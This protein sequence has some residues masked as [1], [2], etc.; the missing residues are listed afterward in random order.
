[1]RDFC[2]QCKANWPLKN[3]WLGVSVE[4]QKTANE[5]IPLLLQTPAAL[6]FVSVEPILGPVDL[7]GPGYFRDPKFNQAGGLVGLDWV[8]VGGESGP[9][10]KPCEIGWIEDVVGQCTMAGVPVFV[11]QDSGRFPGK[12]GRIPDYLWQYKQYPEEQ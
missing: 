6:R 9:N 4:D 2:L 12:Q 11:K 1:M 10:A 5:R 7:I 8:I 3:V